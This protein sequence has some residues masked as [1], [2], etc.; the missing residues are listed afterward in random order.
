MNCLCMQATS[1][2]KIRKEYDT[3]GE[4][5]VPAD[6]Y[7]GAQ[8]ARSKKNFPIGDETER[9]PVRTMAKHEL[10]H[11]ASRVTEKGQPSK[12]FSVT[13]FGT[14]SIGSIGTRVC[15]LGLCCYF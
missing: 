13:I 4:L 11:L 8:T 7:Y 6:R 1:A 3:F 10:P 2:G 5:E 9:M 15:E 14:H 12:F